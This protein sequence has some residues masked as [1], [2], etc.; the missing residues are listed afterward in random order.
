MTPEK[1]R[2]Q[3]DA[4]VVSVVKRLTQE[5]EDNNDNLAKDRAAATDYYNGEMPDMPTKAHRSKMVNKILR[6]TIKKVMPSIIRTLL[7]NPKVFEFVPMEQGDEEGAEQA[8]DFINY[9]VLPESNGDKAIEDA[10]H[11][12]LLLRSGIIK[13]HW[14]TEKSV[15]V[16]THSGLTEEEATELASDD[17]VTVLEKDIT[18]EEVEAE[19]GVV[20]Q[21][22]CSLKIRKV[23]EKQSAAV[24][25]VP[26][27]Q[28]LI[29]PDAKTLDTSPL[30]GQKQR[31]RRGDLVA[32]GFDKDKVMN[33]PAV[34]KD[35]DELED[36]RDDR[37][38]ANTSEDGDREE[39]T[40]KALQEIDYYELYV[41]LD[42]DDDG[43]N[44]LL[45]IEFAG[46]LNDDNLL[47]IDDWDRQPFAD[48]ACEEQPH[49]WQGAGISDDTMD[50][51]QATTALLR[52]V[53]DNVYKTNNPQ[54]VI[55]D[56]KIVNEDAVYNPKHGEPIVVEEGT[57]AKDAIGTHTTAFTADKSFQ[58]LSYFDEMAEDRTG[59]SNASSGMAPDALQNM[60]AKAS[61]MLEA[62]G[63]GQTELMVRSL[64][65][66]LKKL[67][68]LLLHL[69]VKHQQKARTVR[70]R[71]KKWVKYDP[72][73]WNAEMDLTVN[74]GLG[75]GTRERDMAMLMVIKQIQTELLAAFGADNPFV[76]PENLHNM[77]EKL[78]EAAGFPSSDPYFTRPD[79]EEI[80]QKLEKSQNAPNPEMIKA[81]TQIQIEKA[82]AELAAEG[83]K[84][85]I[86]ANRD[87]EK[88][89]MDAD[90]IVRQAEMEKE[91]QAR[92]DEFAIKRDDEQLKMELERDKLQQEWAL[93]TRELD[94]R[95]REIEARRTL[96]LD[97]HAAS[98]MAKALTPKPEPVAA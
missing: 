49:Q 8:S 40:I 98:E 82:K 11:D 21:T 15:R 36:A 23:T 72:R 63:I 70:L 29:H 87:K 2:P 85:E 68:K 26:L 28:F 77:L 3:T 93:K 39:Y 65:R 92:A 38:D 59:I 69:N 12:S 58:M 81:Q 78:T 41:Q 45:K 94:I 60:T 19:D 90:L 73:S 51:Q 75:A 71:N 30:V 27:D 74:T 47:Q 66:G 48:L 67:G 55:Q 64:A 80:K 22:L 95:E 97:R 76:K 25:A 16:S 91:Q 57:S 42:R 44:E 31:L 33:I 17:S 86:Q 34:T 89:Q 79:P 35:T 62:A 9:V 1:S 88:A 96:E 43:L 14:K 53:L 56:G 24:D 84:L 61:A 37:T 46:G 10:V 52:A 6:S 54:P 18:T 5:A 4:Q 13:G 20:D 7:G 83:K 32:M 50:I